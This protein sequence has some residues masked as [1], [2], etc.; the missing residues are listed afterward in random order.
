VDI[1]V[2]S[3]TGT[4]LVVD[5]DT[6]FSSFP[7]EWVDTLSAGRI[8]MIEERW[9][10]PRQTDWESSISHWQPPTEDTSIYITDTIPDT[11]YAGTPPATDTNKCNVAGYLYDGRNLPVPYRDVTF[12]PP[13]GRPNECSDAIIAS[14]AVPVT[15]QTNQDGYFHQELVYSSC[16][17]DSAYYRI[18]WGDA[19]RSSGVFI[20]P[21][22]SLFILVADSLR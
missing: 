18:S 15:V 13:P 10:L 5:Y 1:T 20:V 21:D 19:P 12:T 16:F 9:Y 17:G 22:T 11:I 8:F 7:V 3:N 2:R 6:L 4:N 14:E